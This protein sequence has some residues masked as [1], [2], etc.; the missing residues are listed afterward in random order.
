MANG[1]GFRDNTISTEGMRIVH[2]SY[3]Y[4]KDQTDPEM[5]LQKLDFYTGI[6]EALTADATVISVHC[7]SYS[8]ILRKNNV[9][10]HFLKARGIEK[11]FPVT[12]NMYVKKL[13]PD[14]VVVHG[15]IYPM[16]VLLLRMILDKGCKVIVQ[17]HA[18]R[19]LTNI[20]R[21]I[22][23]CTDRFVNAYLFCAVDLAARWVNKG[24]ISPKR[25][26]Y[27][28][29][30]GSSA[31]TAMDKE[32]ARKKS[33]VSGDKVFLWVGGLHDRKNPLLMVSAFA[34]FAKS[35]PGSRLYIIHQSVE[36]IDEVRRVIQKE[37]A[38]DTVILVGSIHHLDLVYWY[39]SADFIVSTSKYEGSGIAVCEGMSCGCI[40]ILSDIP[41]FKMMTDNG[42]IGFLFSGN[43]RDALIRVLE[44]CER[45]DIVNEKKKVLQ[46]FADALSFPAIANRMISVARSI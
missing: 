32:V 31:F 42:R 27:E 33:K 7:L 43:D 35:A 18:E 4:M 13:R 37:G 1:S 40:P 41:S 23:P 14:I 2:I 25:K 3:A 19:P 20:L 29:M 26:I 45:L 28:V 24:L 39:N 16:H 5:W 44:D 46:Q 11:H 30:E 6:L 22:Q 36:L 21:F 17:H 10:Y 38:S 8:G 12:V 9:E 15:L 34:R